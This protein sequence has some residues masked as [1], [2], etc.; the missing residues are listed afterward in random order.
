MIVLYE[1]NSGKNVLNNWRNTEDSEETEALENLTFR[2]D[3]GLKEEIDEFI[4]RDDVPFDSR[5]QLTRISLKLILE[6]LEEGE[7][8][9]GN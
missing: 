9:G 5:S 8:D 7:F 4:S 3:P 6:S 2:A 1:L